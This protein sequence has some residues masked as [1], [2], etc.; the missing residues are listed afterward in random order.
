[1][2]IYERK[3]LSGKIDRIDTEQN[4]IHPDTRDLLAENEEEANG[5]IERHKI[6]YPDQK[7]PSIP[8]IKI[9]EQ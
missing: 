4:F 7:H 9:K 8:Y 3:L 1:M 2:A 6:Q 5:I